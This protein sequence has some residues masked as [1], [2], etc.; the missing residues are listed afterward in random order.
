MALHL[1]YLSKNAIFAMMTPKSISVIKHMLAIIPIAVLV[2]ACQPEEAGPT[3]DRD[4]FVDVWN[5]VEQSSQIGQTQYDVHINLST[6]NTAQVLLENFYNV[7]FSYKAIA[8]V[9]GSNLTMANQTYNG[10]QLQ[11]TGSMNGNNSINLNYTV[12]D[13]SAIDTCTSTFTRQ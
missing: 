11:G 3:D 10:S 1:P 9:S 6:T 13:G 7:G 8:T 12:N 2:I 5:C 4:K